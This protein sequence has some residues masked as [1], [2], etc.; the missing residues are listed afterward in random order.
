MGLLELTPVEPNQEE[1]MSRSLPYRIIR[2]HCAYA[3]DLVSL[4]I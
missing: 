3:F 4:K 2:T 1:R